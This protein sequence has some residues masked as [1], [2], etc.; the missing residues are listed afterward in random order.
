MLRKEVI[1]ENIKRKINEKKRKRKRD[2]I[3][4][5]VG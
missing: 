2:L 4:K 5:S 3:R 1:L